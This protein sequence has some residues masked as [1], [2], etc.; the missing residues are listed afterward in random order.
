[1]RQPDAEIGAGRDLVGIAL[2]VGESNCIVHLTFHLW[3]K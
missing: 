2:L 1:M 3:L